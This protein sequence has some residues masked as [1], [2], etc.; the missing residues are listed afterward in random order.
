MVTEREPI[1]IAPDSELAR[2]LDAGGETPVLLEKNG[3]FYR[4]VEEPAYQD[5]VLYDTEKVKTAIHNT[6]GSWSDVDPDQFIADLY[7][8]REAGSRPA[9][10]P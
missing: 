7:K 8:A 3:K 4:L 5:G 2:F 10:R 6:T 9:T 1:Q